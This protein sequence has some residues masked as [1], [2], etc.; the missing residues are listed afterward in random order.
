MASKLL[1]R[2]LAVA[3]T[4]TL[5]AAAGAQAQSLEGTWKGT[6]VTDAGPAGNM[7]MVW[8]KDG[9][10]WKVTNTPEGEGVPA[11]TDPRDLKVDG[12]TFEFA[13]TFG[14]IEVLFKG[15]GNGDTIKGTIEAYQGGSLVASGS[16]E[17]KKQ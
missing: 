13:Q 10:A 3:A 12:G 14:D 9:S 11:G 15:T 8:A 16:F 5:S 6:F 17:L 2:A 1:S 4:L 7:T